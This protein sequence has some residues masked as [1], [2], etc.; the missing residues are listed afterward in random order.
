MFPE[1][2]R[3]EFLE[4]VLGPSGVNLQAQIRAEQPAWLSLVALPKP[5]PDA[6]ALARG[7]DA[8]AGQYQSDFYGPVEA[9]PKDAA[10]ALDF[11][12]HRYPARLMH[13][14]GNSFLLSFDNPD[15]APGLVTFEFNGA[16]TKATGF[17]G[18]EI[19]NAF[20]LGYGNFNR[21]G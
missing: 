15:I 13:W 12:E 14:S 19:P 10:L 9:A 2:V 7:L 11:G 16:S 5:P 4:R 18:S 8:F 20:T 3:A 1:A 6:T 17:S 21:V